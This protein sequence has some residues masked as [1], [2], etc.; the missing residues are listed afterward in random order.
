LNAKL[1]YENDEYLDYVEVVDYGSSQTDP[2]YYSTTKYRKAKYTDITEVELPREIYYW[3]IV[4]PKITDEI[5]AFIDPDIIESN[6]FHI[7]NITTPGGGHFW[8]EF[9]FYNADPGYAKFKDMIKG[10]KVVWNEFNDPTGSTSSAIIVMNRW[11]GGSVEFTSNEERPHQP[12]RIYRKHMGRCGEFSDM[13]VA[14]ARSALIPTTSVATYSRDHVWN[15]FWDEDWIH[16]DGATDDPLMYVDDWGKE[17]NS[18]FRWRSDGSFSSV[19]ETYTRGHSILNIYTLDSLDN[20][21]DGATVILYAPG[22]YQ[23]KAF[24]NYSV[25]D[26]EGKVTFIVGA[27]RSYWAR[28][29]C[30]Y[31]SVP[32]EQGQVLRVISNSQDNEEYSVYLQIDKKKPVLD[33]EEIPEPQFNENRYYLEVDVRAPSQILRGKDLFDDMNKNAFQFIQKENGRINYFVTDESDYQSYI[34]GEDFEGFHSFY[35]SD[36][37]SSGFEFDGNS[38]WYCIFDNSNSL[39]TLQHLVGS[40]NL[41]SAYDPEIVNVRILSNFPNPTNPQLS[42]TTILYQLPQKSN[43]ELSIYNTLGQKVKT[44]INEIQYAGQFSVDW[45][46]RNELNQTVSSGVY[47]CKIKTDQ[48]SSSRKIIVVR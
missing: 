32:S 7:N 37:S 34:S 47:L 39:H 19:T 31:G 11:L 10:T 22:L 8:R 17:L 16:W 30:D 14:I 3:Y 23:D 44:L 15:E 45:D 38:N 25:T 2:D 46:G 1:I 13:R 5:P 9:L 48:G 35:D 40:V 24:D 43:V 41:Y 33:W 28:M 4:H 20:P 27:G 12:V 21:I 6:Y 26:S 29:S 18:V 36:L 42:E